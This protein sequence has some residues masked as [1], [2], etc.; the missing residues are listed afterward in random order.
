MTYEVC[1][2]Y[3]VVACA[4]LRYRVWGFYGTVHLDMAITQPHEHKHTVHHE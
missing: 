2:L 4:L 3:Y 1:A